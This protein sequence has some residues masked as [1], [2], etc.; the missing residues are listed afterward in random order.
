MSRASVL[1]GR[2]RAVD[3]AWLA[4]PAGVAAAGAILL[5]A[6]VAAGTARMLAITV[7][8]VSLWIGAPVEPWFT[9]LLGIGLIGAA[10]SAD[11]ALV[12]FG[13]PATWLVVVGI[14][15]GEATSESG[16]GSLVER[17]SRRLV[18]DRAAGDPVAV[19]RYTLLAL[20]AAAFGLAVLVP[21]AL[22]RVLIL[23]PIL[24]S[25]GDRFGERAPR[26]GLF[27]GP[28]FVTFYGATG[29]LTAALPNIVITGLAETTAGFSIGWVEWAVLL[30]PVMGLGRAAAVVAVTYALYR[31]T[32][33]GEVAAVETVEAGDT[34]LS[35][36]QRRMLLFLLV[37]VAVWATDTIHGLHPL[38]G[39]LLVAAL[40]F[41]PRVGVV[42]PDAVGEADFS[43]VFFLGAIFAI[44]EGLRRT[45]FTD[46]AAEAALSVLPAD[47]PLAAVLAAVVA[48]SMGLAFLMEGLAVA[49]VLTPV[50]LSFADSAGVALTPVVMTEAVALNT[51]FFPY[52]S[53]VMV[54]ILGL[55]VVDG[56]E[57]VRMATAC[58]L[59]TLTVLLPLQIGLFV[60]LF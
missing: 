32:A 3:P 22:V 4:L 21:S 56:R 2:A 18:P 17:G 40:A 41:A 31:P 33:D 24:V 55:D 16:L 15:L 46:A 13:S 48:A 8:C 42:G 54:A 25:V 58:T 51:Y 39:A 30:G 12:G 34:G 23:G 29:I 11:L 50:L 28:V 38:F 6:P 1:A 9:G 20:S 14:L 60:L 44:A 5:S 26:I 52:Q 10:F 35:A 49:S 59:L 45:G 47:A 53:A 57:L 36:D 7:F 27:L 43:L 37:G 19:Y